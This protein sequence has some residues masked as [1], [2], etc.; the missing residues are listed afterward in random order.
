MT[1]SFYARRTIALVILSCVALPTRGVSEEIGSVLKLP[2]LIVEGTA[3]QKWRY[4]P[5]PGYE[6]LSRCEDAKTKQLFLAFYRAHELLDAMLPVRF[7]LQLDVPKAMIF[8]DEELWPIA[9]QE[10]VATMLRLNPPSHPAASGDEAR[11]RQSA[12]DSLVPLSGLSALGLKPR[13]ENPES[14]FFGNMCLSDV[15]SITTFAL[16]SRAMVD[17]QDTYLTPA[18]VETLLNRRT[19]Q[20]PAWFRSGFLSLYGKLKVHDG[21]LSIMRSS[22]GGI[23]ASV[24]HRNLSVSPNSPFSSGKRFMKLEEQDTTVTRIGPSYLGAASF[25]P[26]SKTLVNG[27]LPIGT[28]LDERAL[29]HG[30]S[31]SEWLAETELFV[32]WGIDPSDPSRTRA[33]WKF[34]ELSIS[35]P[36]SEQL[37]EK[38]F[39]LNS[40]QISQQLTAFLPRSDQLEW[41]ADKRSENNSRLELRDA[42]RGE[43]AR[44]KGE[45]ERLETRYIRKNLPEFEIPFL[46][47]ARN[48]LH[49]AYARGD[50]DPRLVDSLALLEL[51]AGEI[52]AARGY[53]E[54]AANQPLVRP[55]AN[56]ELARLRYE[57][58]DGRSTRDDGKISAK[59]AASIV[60]PLWLACRQKPAI[61]QVYELMADASVNCAAPPQPATM[62]ALEEGVRLFPKDGELVYR[63]A[64]LN[65]V[66]DP[67]EASRLIDLGLQDASDDSARLRF[68]ELGKKVALPVSATTQ[69]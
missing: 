64:L 67:R 34:V 18:Y 48:T 15:D 49:R 5:F 43:I 8:Y 21:T 10:N 19:P 38:C 58:T 55:R 66:N 26:L 44:I 54:E 3:G 32:R 16:V 28:V 53:L 2:P 31:E 51:D 47:Q 22:S 63:V 13:Q 65:A 24:S 52:P 37:F 46:T 11:Q 6:I 61:P 17:E 9:E 69:P 59:E 45:W 56:F 14:H 36:I 33:F 60:E 12:R 20:L 42:T 39:G 40:A 50:R 62:E 27:V 23:T 7:Q 57:E 30:I 25:A 68:L 29:D 41:S 35:E 4:A 1:P